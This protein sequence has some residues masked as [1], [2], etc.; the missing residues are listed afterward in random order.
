MKVLVTGGSGFVGKTLQKCCPDWI[1]V[2]SSDYDLRD[3]EQCR[4]MYEDHSPDAVLHLAAK[5]GGI[6]VNAEQQ[7][8]F[9]Y[10]NCLI[11][12][13]VIEEAYKAGI[14]RLLAALSTC[15]FPNILPEYPFDESQIFDG[16]PPPT[17]LSYGYAKRLL[18]VQCISYSKQ[19]GVNYTTFS[20]SNLYGP[21]DNS[22]PES[23]H[24]VA[25]MVRKISEAEDGGEVEFWGSG[26]PLKQELFVEDLCEI[27][28][29]LLEKHNTE[30]PL[31]VS[32]DEHLSILEMINILMKKCDKN[33][34]VTFNGYLDGQYRKD[35]SNLKLKELM[36]NFLFTPFS[37]GI[38]KTYDSYNNENSF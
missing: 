2:G 35:G 16:P 13:N 30:I 6:K 9:L 31:L 28:P 20:P 24:F 19:F 1:Y 18:H 15:A 25:A 37:E 3:K 27:L 7:A 34:K 10:E 29:I 33:I 21:G 36:P 11:N 26:N 38:K 14:T 5:V 17:N 32:P 12:L 4:E 8:T 22:N 23:S